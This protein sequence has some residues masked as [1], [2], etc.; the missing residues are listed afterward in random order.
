M[1]DDPL[2]VLRLAGHTEIADLLTGHIGGDSIRSLRQL[3]TAVNAEIDAL[4]KR[5]AGSQKKKGR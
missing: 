1:G 2:M 3:L 4:T 5:P